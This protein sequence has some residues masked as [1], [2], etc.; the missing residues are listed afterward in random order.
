MVRWTGLLLLSFLV[1]LGLCR[2]A[3]DETSIGPSPEAPFRFWRVLADS[4]GDWP[5]I[6]QAIDHARCGDTVAVA[7]GSYRERLV[8]DKPLKLLGGWDALFTAADP[9]TRE[10]VLDGEY[11][12]TV[13]TLRNL[14]D[15]TSVV[16][17]F[18]IIHG[19]DGKCAGG[20]PSA[21]SLPLDTPPGSGI[22]CENACPIISRNVIR[23]NRA[24]FGAGILCRRGAAR[25]R[26]NTITDNEARES[27]GGI[28]CLEF[29][30]S[31]ERNEVYGNVAGQ[32]G[33]GI[34]LSLSEGPIRGGSVYDN[35]A[36][37]GGGGILCRVSNCEFDS[38]AIWGNRAVNFGGGLFIE[39][40]S[41][42][43]FLDCEI[44]ENQTDGEGG[45]A[46]CREDCQP[47]FTLCKFGGNAALGS[48]G[49]LHT[50]AEVMLVQT[51]FVENEAE[52]GGGLMCAAGGLVA[53]RRC[54]FESN[55]AR[56]GGAV[57]V[58]RN[59]HAGFYRNTFVENSASV[60]GGAFYLIAGQIT[61]EANIV[62]LSLGGG[63]IYCWT[64][65]EVELLRNDVWNNTG[66]D[67]GGVCV[68]PGV[69][70]PNGNFSA[71]PLFCDGGAGN[72]C[73]Q[74]L[75]PAVSA[76]GDTLGAFSCGCKGSVEGQ[77]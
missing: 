51:R 75:S 46:Y 13:L 37:R 20:L 74:V 2:C 42:P 23:E 3:D 29:A 5:T 61:L 15:S 14:R 77:R 12:G 69:P 4:S 38:I 58:D 28:L 48:G 63:G 8:V 10:T 32:E 39:G 19:A 49:G 41:S 59:S 50:A 47:V 71:D 17:G 65:A 53:A 25:I 52:R 40:L 6:Q 31:L 36:G 1:F 67:Y 56:T 9:A 72:Y 18:V 54:L 68:E 64:A 44:L 62:V 60:A 45:G 57:A 76:S 24:L 34:Y 7:G 11:L 30:G 22:Y 70:D 73:L 35:E 16:D 55:T 26:S 66:G 43:V 33:G 27:G 21:G